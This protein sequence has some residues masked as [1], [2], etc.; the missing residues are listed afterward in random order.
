M[1]ELRKVIWTS[2]AIKTKECNFFNI[3]MKETKATFILSN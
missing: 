2:I 3:G 1:D